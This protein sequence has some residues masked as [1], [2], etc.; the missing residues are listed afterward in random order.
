MMFNYSSSQLYQLSNQHDDVIKWKHFPRQW[1]FVRGIRRSL[2]NSPHKGHWRGALMISLIWAW[3]DSWANNGDAGDLRRYRAHYDVI[4]ME[5]FTY[6]PWMKRVGKKQ[7][8]SLRIDI[9]TGSTHC[10][11]TM[12]SLWSRWRLKSPASRLFTQPFNQKQLKEKN[13]SCASLVFVRGIHR[14]PVNSPC[15]GP[16]TRKNVSIWWRHH[17]LEDLAVALQMHFFPI[18]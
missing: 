5:M 11:I 16:V 2:V 3:T 7:D 6:E 18:H 12:T 17:P 8:I 4:V 14:W 1:P 15:K 10:P 9:P 13:Q